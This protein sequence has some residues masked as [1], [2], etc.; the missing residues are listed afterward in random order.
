VTA[1]DND[2]AVWVSVPDCENPLPV[3]VAADRGLAPVPVKVM[4]LLDMAA[5]EASS[6]VNVPDTDNVLPHLILEMLFR[7]KVVAC[8][9]TL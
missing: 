8:L 5:L 9:F 6:S 1:N 4:L 7:V 2:S 3:V